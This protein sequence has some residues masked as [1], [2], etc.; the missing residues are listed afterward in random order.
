MPTKW[1]AKGVLFGACSCDWGCPCSFDA[2]PTKGKCEGGYV[3]HIT[4]GRFGDVPL[5]GLTMSWLAHSP[6][7]LHQGNV[8]GLT[9][10][11]ERADAA[12]RAAL[13]TLSRGK[14]G[15]PWVIFGAVMSQHWG[16]KFAPFEVVVN[17][18]NS[19]IRIG[20]LYELELGQILNPVTG[21]AEELYLDKPTGFTSKRLTLGR[22]KVMRLNTEFSLLNFDHSGQYG[23]FSHFDYAGEAAE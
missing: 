9:M 14:S 17:S 5:E 4:E 13:T 19:R 22:S 6:G 16:P 10:I 21:Q 15:G 7:P 18:L 11:E 2:R 12:Q 8:T 20:E 3:W 1:N 23:E